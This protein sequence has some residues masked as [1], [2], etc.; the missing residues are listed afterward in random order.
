MTR[1]INKD[2]NTTD[3][4]SFGYRKD[5]LDYL[6]FRAQKSFDF[7]LPY[8]KPEIEVLECGCGPGVV[9]F[10][11]AKKVINGNVIGI[12]IDKNLI[13]TNNR[14]V[15]KSSFKNLK[16]EVANI[17]ELPYPNNVF[18]IVYMQALLVHIKSPTIAINEVY[19]VLK[20]DGLIAVRE[21]IMN[22]SIFSPEKPILQESF[23]LI[24]KA[25]KSYGGDASIGDKLFTLLNKGGFKNILISASWE[26]PD[27]LDQWSE[28]YEGWSNVFSGRIGDIIIKKKWCEKKYINK[29]IKSWKKLGNE[30]KGFAASPWGEALGFKPVF[31]P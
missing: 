10:E 22:K 12:D 3:C 9:T 5:V 30:Q 25:I 19:R 28:F 23:E 4:Y 24:Q 31:H 16:F 6:T 17:L 20:K 29:I 7:I 18:D 2:Q 21:P 11:I 8:L 13:N 26:Q 27:S 15:I 14:E 1:R